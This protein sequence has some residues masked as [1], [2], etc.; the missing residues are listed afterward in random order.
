M[1][2]ACSRDVYQTDCRIVQGRAFV[3]CPCDSPVWGVLYFTLSVLQFEF[4]RRSVSPTVL[5]FFLLRFNTRDSKI[6]QLA[7]LTWTLW[8]LIN[9]MSNCSRKKTKTA[10]EPELRPNSNCNTDKVEYNT[11][12]IGLSNGQPT[13]ARP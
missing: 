7:S 5:V 10:K 2:N 12:Q 3:G 8:L 4:G 11:T 1:A 6:P 13:K 9:L